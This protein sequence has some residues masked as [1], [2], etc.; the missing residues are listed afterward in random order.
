MAHPP[1]SRRDR[2]SG[3]R[4]RSD[5]PAVGSDTTG[6]H[7]TVGIL[8]P[9]EMGSTLGRLLLSRGIR[10]VTTLEGRSDRSVRMCRESGLEELDSVCEVV[11]QADVVISVVTPAAAIS[12]AGCVAAEL[13]MRRGR[14]L[15]VDVNSVSP[16]TMATIRSILERPNLEL[17]DA[18]IH[19]LASTLAGGGGTL[20]LSGRSAAEVA[21]LVGSPPESVVLG[22]DIGRASLL[23]M[24]IGGVNKGLVALLLEL[25]DVALGEGMLDEFWAVSRVSYPEVIGLFERLLPTYPRHVARR[26][27]EMAELELTVSAASRTPV[28]AT[29]IRTLFERTSRSPANLEALVDRMTA[30]DSG[31][32]ESALDG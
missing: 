14:T 6:A 22:D 11:T 12:V 30:S 3:A 21:V 23:K 7:P 17:V 15:Y 26:G 5:M 32:F 13:S 9:G 28:M 27:E 10:V 8:Y 2:R 1:A 19:G 20:Y 24:L 29:A 18:S 16:T 25:S 4:S 31:R